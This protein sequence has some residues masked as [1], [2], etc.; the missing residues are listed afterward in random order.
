MND[1]AEKLQEAITKKN[2]DITTFIWKGTKTIDENGNYNQIEKR[3]IDMSNT[4]LSTAYEHCKTMLYNKDN[5]NPGRYKVLQIISDQMDRIGA[6]LF[7]R[8]VEK[9]S[10][11]NR[12]NLLKNINTFMSTNKEVLKNVVA[13][14]K[15]AYDN[16]PGE[17]KDVP[18]SLVIDG[19]IDRLGAFNKKHI[20]RTFILKQGIWLTPTESKELAEEFGGKPIDR[21]ALL[22]EKLN[23]KPVEKLFLNA[24]GL[25][26]SQMRAMLNLKPSK[27]YSELSTVQLETLRNKLLFDLQ[28]NVEN[29]I[30]SWQRRMEEIE[31]VANHK[32]Y[33]L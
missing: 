32:N 20:T 3:L 1:I 13:T 26:Y 25:N 23:L 24:K 16:V 19:C 10:D 5:S 12:F 29:H 17:F 30:E 21:L 15:I 2:S 18:I 8:H 28:K 14:I 27:K 4:E 33:K 31:L 9:I 11:L 7:I 6:E 22:R